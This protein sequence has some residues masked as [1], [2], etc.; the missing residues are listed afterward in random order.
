M[1]ACGNGDGGAQPAPTREGSS[2]SIG[3][4]EAGSTSDALLCADD[5]GDVSALGNFQLDDVV[6]LTADM[7]SVTVSVSGDNL[8]VRW[9]MAPGAAA[10]RAIGGNHQHEVNLE[11]ADGGMPYVGLSVGFAGPDGSAN[12]STNTED[13]GLVSTN[14]PDG[15]VVEV[16]GDSILLLVPV[17][18]L[19]DIG[20]EDWRWSAE[21]SAG[22][23]DP[24]SGE[25]AMSQDTCGSRDAG[26][27]SLYV[28]YPGPTLPDIAAAEI[29]PPTPAC[30]GVPPKAD[31]EALAGFPLDDSFALDF[32]GACVF[33]GTSDMTEGVEFSR[34]PA[35]TCGQDFEFDTTGE[36][37]GYSYGL[38]DGPNGLI[39]LCAPD[40]SLL[41][42]VTTAEGDNGP[43]AL[44][45]MRRWL[46]GIQLP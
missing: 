24:V 38:V 44:E 34:G 7:V 10:A 37:D 30:E 1:S 41:I 22:R 32:L 19:A 26:A 18:L 31:I 14:D 43:I 17:A 46:D 16:D 28:F 20:A 21:S 25:Q 9:D 5:P 2:E 6:V 8:A 36:L 15:A 3:N 40:E 4:D 35:S 11:R 13:V 27:G 23:A 29:V 33:S 42:R 39:E 12:L 45:L